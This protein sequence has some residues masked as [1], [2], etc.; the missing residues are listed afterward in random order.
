MAR[1]RRRRGTRFRKAIDAQEQFQQIE[2]RQR[3]SRKQKTGT[4]IDFIEKSKQRERN[5][6]ERIRR[7]EDVPWEFDLEEDA[8]SQSGNG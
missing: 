1:R 2:A 8:G 4:Q 7:P 3:A 5:A 6:F